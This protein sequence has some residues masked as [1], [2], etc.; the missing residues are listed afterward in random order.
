MSARALAAALACIAL[1]CSDRGPEPEPAAART[2]PLADVVRPRIAALEASLPLPPAAGAADPEEVRGVLQVLQQSSGSMRAAALAD[3][4]RLGDGA[5]PELARLASDAAE[6]DALRA[7]AIELLGAAGTQ[8]ASRRLLALLGEGDPQWI[9]AH[10]AWRLTGTRF[11]EVVPGMALR[12]KYETD[13]DT[14]IWLSR[15]LSGFGNY[16]GIGALETVAASSDSDELR[17]SAEARMHEIATAAG[18]DDAAALRRAWTTGEGLPEPERSPHFELE[19]WR[20]I[21][22]FFEFQLRNVDDSRFVLESLGSRAAELLAEALHDRNVYVRVHSAQSLER[23]GPRGRPAGETLVAGLGD[24]ELAPNAAAALGALR[25]APAQGALVALL[26]P[27]TDPELRLAAL[28]ALGRFGPDAT[29]ETRAALAAAL[30]RERLPEFVQAAAEGLALTGGETPALLGTLCRFLV[31]PEVEP[32]TTERAL[33]AWIATRADGGDQVAR[34]ALEE[35]DALVIPN[36]ELVDPAA[37]L[38]SRE[39]R[40]AL[41]EERF[42]VAQEP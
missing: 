28:R 29:A 31:A 13:Y 22:R 19:V 35:W 4:E 34:R 27:A 33:R 39:R 40:R 42:D 38:A 41:V 20:L 37:K 23:M 14:V 32:I 24:P 6:P 16:S 18:Y 25:Y 26:V 8:E 15:A 30:A 10:A 7:A 5:V 21:E 9:R 1:A 2:F 36:D 11:D 12:L 3:A 17:A